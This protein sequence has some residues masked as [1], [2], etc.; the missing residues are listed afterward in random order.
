MKVIQN[1]IT[2]S[3]LNKTTIFYF[4][5]ANCF[6]RFRSFSGTQHNIEK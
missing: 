6:G 4:G 1:Q 2:Y 5:I 3:P